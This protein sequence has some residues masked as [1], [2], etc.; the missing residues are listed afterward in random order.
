MNTSLTNNEKWAENKLRP[1]N[2]IEYIGQ[3]KIINNLNIALSA[4]DKRE[5]SLEHTLFYGPPGLG[6]TSLAL[7]ISKESK[8]N[9]KVTSGP[10][11]EKQSDLASIL[12]NLKSNDILFIDEI[13]RL[14]APVEELLYSAMEDFALDIMIGKG[15]AA[16]SMRLKLPSFTLIGATTKLSLLSSPLRDRFGHI[17]K[18]EFYTDQELAKIVKQT[19]NFLNF[20]IADEASIQI[21]KC[22]RGTPR[23]ANRIIKRARDLAQ[24]DNQKSISI[25]YANRTLESLGIDHIGLNNMDRNILAT[26]FDKTTTGPVGIN[27]IAAFLS[28]ESET[29]EQIY[30]PFLLKLGFIERTSR[31][32]IITQEG[33]SHLNKFKT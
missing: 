7:L 16:R 5:E 31:G 10:S 24:L 4:A 22:S 25:D 18:F 2:F 12:S 28:E 3:T 1:K 33:I 26:L 30:E 15:P 13:H 17:F 9:I 29:I 32:R 8:K 21:A 27:T 20:G 23:I 11:I 19:S 6:K 14:R